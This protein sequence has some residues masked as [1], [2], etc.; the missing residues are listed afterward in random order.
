MGLLR[1][2][3]LGHDFEF[4]TA[5]GVFSHTRLDAGTRL[6]IEAMMLPA[7]GEALDLGCGY[8]PI[9][10]AAAKLEPRLMV[11]MTD[12]NRRAVALAEENVRRNGV[13]N[14]RVL[15]G[16]LYEP[17][18][19]RSFEVILTNPPIS[20]G[21]AGA[22]GPLIEGSAAHLNPGGSLQM[23]VR[24]AKG[25]RSVAG[26]LE[27]HYGGFEVLARRGGYRVLRAE[28]SREPQPC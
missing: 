9:G 21:I 19:G 15:T 17:L 20:A 23:V 3:L 14:V 16:F 8:G 28:R 1:C 6:L 25:G 2:R 7:S 13:G 27:K 26:L 22:V 10:I 11:W 18:E 12:V 5:S 4:L 24:T